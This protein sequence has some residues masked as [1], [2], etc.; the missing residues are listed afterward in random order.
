MTPDPYRH[1]RLSRLDRVAGEMNAWL[2]VL[3]IGLAL[4]DLTVFAAAR[5]PLPAT[6][7]ETPAIVSGP[8]HAKIAPG[9]PTM[10]SNCFANGC[11]TGF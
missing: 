11:L 3:A 10:T 1:P 2:V 8:D 7:Y 4:L 6:L 5:V 9:S